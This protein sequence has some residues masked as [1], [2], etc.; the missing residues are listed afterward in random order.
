MYVN[1][2]ILGVISVLMIEIV[3]VVIFAVQWSTKE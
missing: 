2:F 3:L 1:P